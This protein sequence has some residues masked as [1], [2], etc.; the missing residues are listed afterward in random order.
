M[1][2]TNTGSRQRP[3][4]RGKSD[5]AQWHELGDFIVS[6][7]YVVDAAG[8]R[9]LETKVHYSQGDQ[10]MRWNGAVWTELLAWIG[11]HAR[12]FLPPDTLPTGRRVSFDFEEFSVTELRS[13]Q[14]DLLR[15]SAR[16][17]L[18]DIDAEAEPVCYVAEFMLT[19]LATRRQERAAALVDSH[20]AEWTRAI[21]C[22]F[23]VPPPGD[24]DLC[25]IVRAEADADL[26]AESR[27]LR[28]KVESQG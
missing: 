26:L 28:I 10:P 9:R 23:P 20:A 6:F 15:A 19:D 11:G 24:Y 5:S 7:G 21:E 17:R 4:S 16:L 3:R 2:A 12:Q 18:R 14:P 27:T 25:A 13:G 8:E 1:K 22:D